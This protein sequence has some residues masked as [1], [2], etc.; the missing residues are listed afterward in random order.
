[1][2]TD[3]IDYTLATDNVTLTVT[4]GTQITPT[5]TWSNPSSITYGTPLSATQ[6]DVTAN[7]CGS[8]AYSP[9]AGTVLSAGTQTLSVLFTPSDTTDYTSAT[10]TASINIAQHATTATISASTP[11]GA[12]DRLSPSP[13]PFRAGYRPLPADRL[14]PV[15][16]QRRQCRLA[17]APG[18]ERDGLLFDDRAGFR[19][20]HRHRG[21]F[22]RHEPH[23]HHV[24]WLQR[25]RP[26]SRRLRR[27]NHAV[28]RGG[29]L[30]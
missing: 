2:P 14:G 8:V 13:R 12:R 4:Q 20:L 11:Q 15:P 6:L 10:A 27:R 1:M 28:R 17:R 26:E 7:V 3:T 5:I 25:E 22:R 18:L 9:A 21:L 19:F 30:V 23:R 24:A 29:Q 16:D